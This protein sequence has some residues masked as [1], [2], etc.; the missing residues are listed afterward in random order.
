MLDLLEF[1]LLQVSAFKQWHA[2]HLVTSAEYW[3]SHK[4]RRQYRGIEFAPSGS[5]DGYY[6]L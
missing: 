1:R 4:E 6:N 5:R 3:L 2:N